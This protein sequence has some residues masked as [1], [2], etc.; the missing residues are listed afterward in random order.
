MMIT[1]SVVLYNTPKEE[2]DQIL[3]SLEDSSVDLVYVIDHSETEE[4]RPIVEKFKKC[5]YE[6]HKNG[7]YGTGHNRG[8]RKAL[9]A[10]SKYH[11]VINPDVFWNEDVIRELADFM[12]KEPECGLVMPRILFPNG[13]IQYLCKL[14]PTPMDLIGRRFIPLKGYTERHNFYY[15]MRWSGYDRVMEIPC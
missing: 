9:S 5:R 6:R 3:G 7:G 11:A 8:I 10:G 1:A 2:I 14:L 12:D 4:S 15:E 13:E